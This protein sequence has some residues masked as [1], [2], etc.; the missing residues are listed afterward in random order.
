[1]LE[2]SPS[3]LR[4]QRSRSSRCLVRQ[5]VR[6]GVIV[7]H[8]FIRRFPAGFFVWLRDVGDFDEFF[9]DY[10]LACP[11][12]YAESASQID[13]PGLGLFVFFS[14]SGR[15][16]YAR[17]SV[18]P[19]FAKQSQSASALGCSENLFIL[20]GGQRSGP[21]AFCPC[22]LDSACG[23]LTLAA[24]CAGICETEPILKSLAEIS[25]LETRK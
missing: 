11:V 21:C 19:G 24:R 22:A 13:H 14:G 18:R 20:T 6:L 3:A 15:L 16:A 1:M 9:V 5:V 10:V 7:E 4:L 12:I 8:H 25:L 23:S 17:G 2:L